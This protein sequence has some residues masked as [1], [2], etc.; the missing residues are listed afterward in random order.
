MR[1]P[2]KIAQHLFY[3]SATRFLKRFC[4]FLAEH[5]KP[6]IGRNI[7]LCYSLCNVRRLLALLHLVKQIV[8]NMNLKRPQVIFRRIQI[9][10]LFY[11]LRRNL[12]YGNRETKV[13]N[14]R[15]IHIGVIQHVVALKV[16]MDDLQANEILYPL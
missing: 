9:K 1:R 7:L 12:V 13:N 6:L 8:Y 2:I 4:E 10:I 5:F 11:I 15:V 14:I 3:L 16:K